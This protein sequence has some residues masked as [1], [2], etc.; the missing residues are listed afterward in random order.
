MIDMH[1]HILPGVDDGASDLDEALEMAR[2]AESE[3]ITKIVCTPHFH[4]DFEY[5]M[6]EVLLEEVD[7][8][9][10]ELRNKN[11]D[12]EVYIG[13][14]LYYSNEVIENLDKLNFHSLNKSKY[15]L[16]EFAPM[17]LPKNLADVVYEIKLKG[18]TPVLAHV[19]RYNSVIENPNVIYDCIKEG[20]IIQVN[21]SSILGKHGKEIKKTTEILLDNNMVHIVASDAHGSERRRP[22]LK[23]AYEYIKSNYSKEKANDLF[24][25]NQ[26]LII[27]NEDIIIPIASKYEEKRGFFSKLFKR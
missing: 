22:Q 15:I 13:N 5:T 16:I 18:Y 24:K 14:E 21:A 25:N 27:T 2:I 10:K 8:L 1:C 19:E 7:N 12:V 9:N 11:V 23:E 6:G 26:S 3:G 20:A 4:P 17:N